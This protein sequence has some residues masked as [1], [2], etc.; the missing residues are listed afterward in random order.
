MGLI[1]A[2]PA[3][4]QRGRVDTSICGSCRQTPYPTHVIHDL[5]GVG[6]VAACADPRHCR[7]R[8]QTLG[9]W[10]QA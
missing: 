10:C 9:I 5:P 2:E 4:E 6:R 8:A 3:A 7:V 1:R